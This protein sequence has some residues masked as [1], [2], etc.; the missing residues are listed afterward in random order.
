MGCGA[1]ALTAAGLAVSF[2]HV[3]SA[4]GGGGH[5]GSTHA[6]AGLVLAAGTAAHVAAAALRPRKAEFGL[7]GTPAHARRRAWEAAHRWAGAGLLAL[8][9]AVLLS[10][11]TEIGA[12]VTRGVYVAYAAAA[13][14]AAAAAEARRR[15]AEREEKGAAEL[16]AFSVLE[17]VADD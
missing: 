7:V 12:V 10:G 3:Q 13:A 8:A 5:L 4:A 6:K 9:A 1:A 16:A 14:A 17:H 15:R 2:A 11:F